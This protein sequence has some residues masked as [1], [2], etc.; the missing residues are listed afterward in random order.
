MSFYDQ[1]DMNEVAPPS[2]PAVL[3]GAGAE[4]RPF[5]RTDEQVVTENFYDVEK[6]FR[7]ATLVIEEGLLDQMQTPGEAQVAAREWAMRFG[8]LELSDG[9][10]RDI[11]QATVAAG[12]NAPNAETLAAWSAEAKAALRSEY[13]PRA[14]LVL[15]STQKM[16]DA[17]PKLKA[18]LNR[19]G[20]GN[21]PRVALAL[22]AAADRFAK[23]GKLK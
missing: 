19:S 23:A 22:A 21:H 5:A 10:A 4:T 20:T 13:G 12:R 15:R 18:H 11:A 17:D 8:R 16:I 6:T 9:E 14:G 1:S 7:G 3:L 2:G